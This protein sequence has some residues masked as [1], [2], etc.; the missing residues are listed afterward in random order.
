MMQETKKEK[1]KI[2]M[3]EWEMY[4]SGIKRLMAYAMAVDAMNGKAG[5]GRSV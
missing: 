2:L 1:N 3:Y 5:N 4:R